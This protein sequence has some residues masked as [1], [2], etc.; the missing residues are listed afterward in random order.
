MSNTYFTCKQFE[1][2]Q[3]RCAMKVST[4]A[5]IQGAWAAVKAAAASSGSV[6]DIG[7]GT[8][9]LS[10]MLAQVLPE[11]S[12]IKGIELDPAA[13]VQAKENVAAS[14]WN[15]RMDMEAISL[16]NYEAT[17]DEVYD[18]IICNPP[19]F[20]KHLPASG[21]ERQWARHSESLDKPTLA[22]CIG[23]LLRQGGKACI[24]YPAHEWAAWMDAATDTGLYLEQCL[25]IR[26][27]SYKDT[28][29]ICGLLGTEAGHI[30]PDEELIIYEADKSYTEKA[31]ELLQPYYLAL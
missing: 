6:L 10:L 22:R 11:S 18:F 20:H 16:Q 14:P 28:N 24:L 15:A 7:C 19:F 31:R 1:I 13:A 30:L 5:C 26:P 3:D 23:K 9:L 17:T 2:R 4:D 12:R 8:G 21:K 27:F 25:L 29:R